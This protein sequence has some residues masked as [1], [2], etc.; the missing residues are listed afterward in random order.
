MPWVCVCVCVC[1]STQTHTHTHTLTI[2]FWSISGPR[3][4]S[5]RMLRL[6]TH[7]YTHIATQMTTPCWSISGPR[8]RFVRMLRWIPGIR[9]CAVV[10][11]FGALSCASFEFVRMV[12]CHGSSW[13]CSCCLASACCSCWYE[14]EDTCAS[15]CCSCCCSAGVSPNAADAAGIPRK[16]YLHTNSLSAHELGQ[17]GE[18]SLK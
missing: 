1:V 12:F 16:G 11:G 3:A 15:A 8:K 5:V 4:R 13:C 7:Y 6:I 10:P 17:E 14:E 9:V 18:P 2:P